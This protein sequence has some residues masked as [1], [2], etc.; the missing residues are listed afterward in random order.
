MGGVPL[1]GDIGV[2]WG[3]YKDTGF[4]VSQTMLRETQTQSKGFGFPK[5]RDITPY[6]GESNGK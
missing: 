5:I 6:I 1:K 4:R 2:I 3:L